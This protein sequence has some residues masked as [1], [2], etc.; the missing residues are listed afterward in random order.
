MTDKT[1]PFRA[2]GPG[3]S[4]YDAHADDIFA[5]LAKR[6]PLSIIH[7]RITLIQKPKD[8]RRYQTLWKWADRRAAGYLPS[9]KYVNLGEKMKRAIETP[10]P[11][12]SADR[13]LA[14]DTAFALLE[15]RK[16][17]LAQRDA[18]AAVPPISIPTSKIT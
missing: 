5:L 6:T 9:S 8:R 12:M 4:P 1:K 17:K 18:A 2:G 11:P 14:T 7:A 15:A 16:A 13:P 3:T 10:A